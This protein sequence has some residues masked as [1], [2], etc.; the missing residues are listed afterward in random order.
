MSQHMTQFILHYLI[1]HYDTIYLLQSLIKEFIF[2]THWLQVMYYI[3]TT[4]AP[5]YPFTY[6]L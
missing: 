3:L 4:L 2:I 1:D 5:P 6:N